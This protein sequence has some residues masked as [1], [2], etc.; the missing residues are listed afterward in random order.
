MSETA[1]G[2]LGPAGN[3]VRRNVQRLR[4]QRFWSYKEL[5]R[6]LDGEGHVIGNLELAELERGE[7]R[8]DVDDLVAL[9]AVFGLSP[10]ELLQTA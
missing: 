5:A 8:V 2:P 1:R 3:N 6:R 9:A 10:G 4:L 7:R